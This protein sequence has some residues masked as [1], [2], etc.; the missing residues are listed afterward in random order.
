[1]KCVLCTVDKI[2]GVERMRLH[3][4]TDCRKIQV[5][6]SLCE[7]TLSRGTIP[8]HNCEPGLIALVRSLKHKLYK[9]EE[10]LEYKLGK[11]NKRNQK[12]KDKYADLL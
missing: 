4:K 10:E 11:L 3:L 5:K 2:K 6:C 7:V 8:N 9:K 1:M 12:L